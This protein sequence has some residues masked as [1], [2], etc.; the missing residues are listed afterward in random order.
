MFSCV[1]GF[2]TIQVGRL[3]TDAVLLFFFFL[4]PI[5][6][7]SFAYGPAGKGTIL[8]C[9]EA[10]ARPSADTWPVVRHSPQSKHTLMRGAAD[11]V[12]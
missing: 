9:I 2:R 1:R 4:L 3:L 11:G 6:I 12:N 8:L 10:A 7:A 5:P